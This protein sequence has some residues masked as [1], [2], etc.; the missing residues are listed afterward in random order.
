MNDTA[1]AKR[2]T[3]RKLFYILLFF[4]FFFLIIE[5]LLSIVYYQANGGSSFATAGFFN[6]IKYK[7]THKQDDR[8]GAY[9]NQQL[10][11]PDSSEAVNKII[12]DEAIE[13]NGFEFQSWVGFSA[14]AYKGRYLNINGLIRKTIP[15][16]STASASPDT[17]LIYFMGGSTMFGFNVADAET[18]PSNFVKLCLAQQYNRPVKVVNYGIPAY[19]SYNELMLLTN[20]LYAGKRPDLV[21]FFDGLNDFIAAKASPF[22]K[23]IIYYRMAQAFS[24]DINK[25][26]R[27]YADSMDFIFTNSPG[28]SIASLSDSM[29]QNYIST[30]SSIET[31]SN[32]YRV[33]PVFF[34]QP[35]PYYNY[36][37]Q[38]KDPICSQLDYPQYKYIYPKLEAD[39]L[40][41]SNLFFLG[42]MLSNETG[43][44]YVDKFHYSP[45]INEKIAAAMFQHLHPII[46]SLSR[47]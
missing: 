16:V 47:K 43:I 11:R 35:V 13:A 14:R 27:N 15:E 25:G 10:A 19:Y 8:S 26:N 24:M 4:V 29:Y 17:L 9:K 44:T 34:V 31:I 28:S 23:P 46:D 1:T 22:K 37:N 12:A 3:G 30:A 36:P 39:A 32:T 18:I 40:K 20:L 41:R 7:L 38:K 6:K 5:S 33:K 21:V 2:S 42:N 45:K